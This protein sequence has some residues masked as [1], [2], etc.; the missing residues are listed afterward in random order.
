MAVGA[1]L[2]CVRKRF[3]GVFP[4]R[5]DWVKVTVLTIVTLVGC[6]FGDW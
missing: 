1:V 6:Y 2:D 5:I 4:W 3:G